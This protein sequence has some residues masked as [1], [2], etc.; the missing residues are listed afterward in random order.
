[1]NKYALPLLIVTIGLLALSGCAV[2]PKDQSMNGI[3]NTTSQMDL[4][5]IKQAL[6]TKAN[7]PAD[8]TV[9]TVLQNTGDHARGGV[10]YQDENGSGGGYWFAVK[11]AAGW[12]IVLDGNGEIPCSKMQDEGFPEAMIPDC[13]AECK[14]SK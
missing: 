4:D 3:G 7:W 13:C 8:K 5:A 14:P 6:A 12:R 2:K 11:E 10:M 9:I 1:M